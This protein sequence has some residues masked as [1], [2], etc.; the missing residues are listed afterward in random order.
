LNASLKQTLA[1]KDQA[2]TESILREQSARVSNLLP[3]QPLDGLVL[4]IQTMGLNL[5]KLG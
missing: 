1:D 5:D 3:V 4:A 2:L